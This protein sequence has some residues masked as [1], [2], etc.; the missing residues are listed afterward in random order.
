MYRNE[1]LFKLIYELF[2]N[3]EQL[4]FFDLLYKN[5]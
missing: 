3:K 1:L 2:F 5:V 4:L